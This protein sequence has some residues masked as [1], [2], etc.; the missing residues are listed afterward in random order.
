[1][2]FYTMQI[3]KKVVEKWKKRAFFNEFFIF[4][5]SESKLSCIFKN[6]LQTFDV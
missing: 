2:G 4:N 5:G 3:E 1:M 6:C